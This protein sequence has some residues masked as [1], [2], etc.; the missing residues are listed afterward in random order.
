[1]ITSINLINF[2]SHKDTEI[3]F[4]PGVNCIIG[5]SRSGKTAILRGLNWC[6]YNKPNGI[7]LNSYWNRDKK[8]IKEFYSV[9]VGFQEHAI[10]RNRDN[11]FNGY[12]CDDKKYEALGSDVPEEIESIWNM[13]EINIQK[14]F[15][16]PYL[17]GESSAEVARILNKTIKLDKIDKV[18]S[19][20]E[21]R[22]RKLNQNIT[23]EK[24]SLESLKKQYSR[25]NWMD[26]AEKLIIAA[27]R[28]HDRI[29]SKQEEKEEL[30]QLVNDI[31]KLKEGIIEIDFEPVLKKI[32]KYRSVKENLVKNGAEAE[33]LDYLLEQIEMY[34]QMIEEVPEGI[35]D[36]IILMQK[37]EELD[38]II[39]KKDAI[40]SSIGHLL[41]LINLQKEN[42]EV[43]ER[44]LKVLVSQMPE[45]C[46]LC[47]AKLDKEKMNAE[48]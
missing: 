14:Q 24:E 42:I 19:E 16:S 33:S 20:A 1:M 4:D 43:E 28:R 29:D 7:S 11:T 47:G 8:K 9:T 30:L 32:E 23:T 17:L 40:F 22:R 48:N 27:E 41:D 37:I 38:S 3:E 39:D 45:T 34:Y 44:N 21:S 46:V 35:D 26:D 36:V 31:N 12:W 13:N 2:Q 25:M 5:S 10:V 6:R 18:L 15:D